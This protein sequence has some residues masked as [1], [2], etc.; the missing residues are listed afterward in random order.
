MAVAAG[1]PCPRSCGSGGSGG[2]RQR[3]GGGSGSGCSCRPTTWCSARSAGEVRA[4][5]GGRACP[6]GGDVRR[7]RLRGCTWSVLAQLRDIESYA[8][9]ELLRREGQLRSSLARRAAAAECG[10]PV[11]CRHPRRR[12]HRPG[13]RCRGHVGVAPRRRA[14]A[15]GGS[16]L[17][18]LG[19]AG[20]DTA[21]RAGS[22]TSAGTPR[23]PVSASPADR[24]V[25]LPQQ[26]GAGAG[27][28]PRDRARCSACGSDAHVGRAADPRQRRADRHPGGLGPKPRLVPGRGGRS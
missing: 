10:G 7:A 13:R 25:D 16:S 21:M 2:P 4:R 28:V 17:R 15:D 3:C 22:S 12:R 26:R 24:A 19:T 8:D 11:P 9:T 5:C 18:V 1:S 14:H 23:C 20:Y 6:C 27:S